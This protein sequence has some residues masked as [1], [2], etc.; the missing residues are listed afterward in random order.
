MLVKDS[1]TKR[2]S[3]L[4]CDLDSEISFSREDITEVLPHE[5]DHMII[6]L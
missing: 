3:D 2:K 4:E 5:N 1:P 6:K